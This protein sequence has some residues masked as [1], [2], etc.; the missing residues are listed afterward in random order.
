[1]RAKYDFIAAY[2]LGYADVAFGKFNFA[3]QKG[4]K[5]GC[6]QLGLLYVYAPKPKKDTDK[7]FKIFVKNCDDGHA[8]SCFVPSWFYAGG[9]SATIDAKKSLDMIIKSCDI[10]YGEGCAE[11]ARA[12]ARSQN[13]QQD[14]KKEQIFTQRPAQTDT[15]KVAWKR[16]NFTKGQRTRTIKTDKIFDVSCERGIYEACYVVCAICQNSLKDD[17]AAKKYYK[18][19]AS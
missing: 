9:I 7:A 16:K 8:A 1:M 13:A 6:H 17:K 19:A 3:C 12:Y 15:S 11:P 5:R 14:V 4:D 2:E 10:G 18:N